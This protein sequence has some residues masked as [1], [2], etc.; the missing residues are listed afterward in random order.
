METDEALEVYKESGKEL[1]Q[2]IRRAKRG[3]EKSLANWIK[4]NPKAFY[5][6]AKSKRVTWERVGPF[7][8]KEGN[9]CVEPDDVGEVLNEYFVSVFTKEKELVEDDVRE[10]SVEYQS[11]VAIKKERVLCILKSMKVDRSPG[12]DGIYP[13]ILTEAREQIAGALTGI[14]V[15]SLAT[16]EVP[17]DWKIANVVALFKKG[18]RDNPTNY[19]P[20]S[21]ILVVGKLLGKILGE[22]IY[23]HLEAN[24]HI[25]DRQHGF[26]RWR[27]CLTNLIEFFEEVIKMIDEGKVV[28]VVYM[29]FSK[30]FDKVPHGRLVHSIR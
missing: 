15:S 30:A 27:S 12:P 19:K 25:S 16:G 2:R 26:V 29:V 23:S 10:G 4:E 22:K 21:L 24:G 7:K 1:K 8:D 3:H 11:Q 6:Y 28:H 14:F 17:E 13:R 9:L 5:T 20:V 18:S